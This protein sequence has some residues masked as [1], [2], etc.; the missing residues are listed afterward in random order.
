ISSIADQT[1]TQDT[2]TAPIPFSIG[3]VQTDPS[4][5]TVT[6]HSSN[7]GLVPEA[8]IYSDATGPHRTVT[9]TPAGGQYGTSTIS[10]NVAD[11]D[12]ASAVSSFLLTVNQVNIRTSMASVANRGAADATFVLSANPGRMQFAG[13][14]LRSSGAIRVRLTGSPLQNAT[15]QVS[16]NLSRWQ[17]VFTNYDQTNLVEWIDVGATDRW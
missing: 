11:P 2:P 15:I 10:I 14:S 6:G 7:E 17:P 16:T 5:L 9:I 3:D 4:G 13:N 8:N 1:T 12:G